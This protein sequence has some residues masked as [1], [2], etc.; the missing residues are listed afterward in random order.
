MDRPKTNYKL[1]PRSHFAWTVGDL[2]MKIL[3]SWKFFKTF[4]YHGFRTRVMQFK[5]ET[6]PALVE[7]MKKLFHSKIS[8]H[9]QSGKMSVTE[10]QSFLDGM[11]H[12]TAFTQRGNDE[13]LLVGKGSA[14]CKRRETIQDNYKAVSTTSSS[15]FSN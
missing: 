4:F 1:T 10:E 6:V 11:K 12:D 15:N 8:F 7:S 9:Y 3:I 5:K 14:V 13:M 2:G